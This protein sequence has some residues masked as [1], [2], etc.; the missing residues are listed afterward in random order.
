MLIDLL[1]EKNRKHGEAESKLLNLQHFLRLPSLRSARVTCFP[2]DSDRISLIIPK[3][4]LHTRER[5]QAVPSHLK[6]PEP[7]KKDSRESRIGREKRPSFLG[8]AGRPE[9]RDTLRGW[10]AVPGDLFEPV[11]G[12]P[13]EQP[14]SRLFILRARGYIFANKG[15]PES[16]KLRWTGAAKSTWDALTKESAQSGRPP[17]AMV[18]GVRPAEP[19]GVDGSC[20]PGVAMRHSAVVIDCEERSHPMQITT[21]G[22]DLAKNTFQVH[23]ITADGT[24]AFNKSLRRAQLS[25]FFETLERC[26]I[27]ME[28]CGS[29]HHWARQFRKLG[30]EVRLMPAMYVKAYVKTRQV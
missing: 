11:S 30:H 6:R 29:S 8:V 12:K 21:V 28:A 7:W 19:D 16:G 2:I 20:S 1:S 5:R 14:S 24:V 26:L 23:G 10:L 3:L 4:T 9:S 25:Q 17:S 22:P 27:G 13:V 15:I 18:S